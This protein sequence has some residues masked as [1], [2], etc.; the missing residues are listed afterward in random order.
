MFL[1]ETEETKAEITSLLSTDDKKCLTSFIASIKAYLK[2]RVFPA[3]FALALLYMTVLGFDGLAVSHGKSHNLSE[4]F[5][6]GFRSISSALGIAGCFV[7]TFTEQK[8]GVRKT[9]LIG[10]IVSFLLEAVSNLFIL[11]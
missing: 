1:E 2:Q 7:Y 8:I 11:F 3:A 5:I 6:G 10:L 9:G 4:D